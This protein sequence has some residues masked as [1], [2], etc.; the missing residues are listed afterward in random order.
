MPS[1]HFALECYELKASARLD[2]RYRGSEIVKNRAIR[3]LA[4]RFIGFV[5]PVSRDP[6]ERLTPWFLVPE[7]DAASMPFG[8]PYAGSLTTDVSS[9]GGGRPTAERSGA[10]ADDPGCSASEAGGEHAAAQSMVN[11][12]DVNR[13][14]QAERMHELMSRERTAAASG[15]LPSAFLGS[16]MWGAVEMRWI[17]AWRLALLAVDLCTAYC[18]PRCTCGDPWQTNGTCRGYGARWSCNRWPAW[19]GGPAFRS[20]PGT[21]TCK[22]RPTSVSCGWR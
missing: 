18:T 14:V 16:T 5:R 13:R 8:L 9:S 17:V 4:T 2:P 11:E 22:C 6:A 21:A 10:L 3:P 19:S 12:A 15:A 1:A 20:W 7:L